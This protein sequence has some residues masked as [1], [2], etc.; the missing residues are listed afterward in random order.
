[1]F[2]PAPSASGGDQVVPLKVKAPVPPTPAQ[3]L[4]VGQETA[5]R[6][7]WVELTC[8]GLDQAVPLKV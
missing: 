5:V 4:V 7:P 6:M 8:T 2:S 1:M 3:K